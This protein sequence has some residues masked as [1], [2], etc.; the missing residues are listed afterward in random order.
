[1]VIFELPANF[2]QIYLQWKC[3]W[4]KW[5]LWR[6][7]ESKVF[8]R[9]IALR[10]GGKK[11]EGRGGGKGWEGRGDG[12]RDASGGSRK[13]QTREQDPRKCFI[14]PVVEEAAHA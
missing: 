9:T 6:K 14:S 3:Y 2:T 5:K 7:G 1:M 12:K 10:E 4:C 8:S 13:R 11:E